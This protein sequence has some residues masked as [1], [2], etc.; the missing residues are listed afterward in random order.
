MSMAR[1]SISFTEK[2]LKKLN[3]T[4]GETFTSTTINIKHWEFVMDMGRG[5]KGRENGITKKQKKRRYERAQ[6]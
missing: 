3:I 5:R 2:E 4:K 1:I 6:I